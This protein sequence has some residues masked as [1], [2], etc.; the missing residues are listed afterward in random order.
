MKEINTICEGK[1]E[2]KRFAKIANYNQKTS[3]ALKKQRLTEALDTLSEL[4]HIDFGSLTVYF[5]QGKWSP[6]IEIKRN[7][8]KEIE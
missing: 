8:L 2:K 3:E 6:K 7:I 5:H 4:L 1:M